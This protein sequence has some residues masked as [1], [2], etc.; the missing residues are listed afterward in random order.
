MELYF[1][2]HEIILYTFLLSDSSPEL[3]NNRRNVSHVTSQYMNYSFLSSLCLCHRPKMKSIPQYI[4]LN[5]LLSIWITATLYFTFL[6][7]AGIALTAFSPIFLR[8]SHAFNLIVSFGSPN[9][10]RSLLITSLV[11]VL[12]RLLP[13]SSV[14]P[15]SEIQERETISLRECNL[16]LTVRKKKYK[17]KTK[18]T[19]EKEKR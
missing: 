13:G 18:R 17:Q 7:P 1:L 11:A 6:T 16:Y 12:Y 15:G 9:R 8:A 4:Q 14:R 3:C 19:K 10:R 2:C 5:Y